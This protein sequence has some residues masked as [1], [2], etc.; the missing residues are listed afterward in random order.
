MLIRGRTDFETTRPT[1]ARGGD[2]C[3]IFTEDMSSL[4]RLA[5]LLTAD[6]DTAERCFVEALEECIRA[7]RVFEEW[8]RSWAR[9]A[10]VQSA[11]R[12]TQPTLS[13]VTPISGRRTVTLSLAGLE[14]DTGFAA[15]FKLDDLERFVFVIVVLEGYSDQ[16]CKILL[17]R[18][19]EQIVRARARAIRNIAASGEIRAPY[20]DPNVKS[21]LAQAS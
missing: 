2:F 12:V 10:V 16:D 4:Y 15:I 7:N 21:L 1:Y 11:I 9:R 5:F 13:G 17:G 14:N 20:A 19:R 6:A 3:R 8:A 18:S